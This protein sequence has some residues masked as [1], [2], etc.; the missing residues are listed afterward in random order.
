MTHVD[1]GDVLQRSF[2]MPV[3]EI[4]LHVEQLICNL[5]EII[6]DANELVIFYGNHP[7]CTANLTACTLL[8]AR[9]CLVVKWKWIGSIMD[10]FM[11][12]EHRRNINVGIL[13]TGPGYVGKST[14]VVHI[15][16]DT[17]VDKNAWENWNL[18]LVGHL[19]RGS[20]IIITSNSDEIRDFGTTQALQLNFLPLE[21][22]LYFFKILMFRSADPSDHPKLE[23]VALE[24]AREMN[25]SFIAANAISGI[26]RDNLSDHYWSMYLAIFKADI[27]RNVSLFGEHPY[28]LMQNKKHACY[29]INNKDQYLVCAEYLAYSSG[30]NVP[31]ITMYDVSGNVKCGGAFKVLA[32]KSHVL[33]Y[34][35]YIISCMIEKE[36]H[37][38]RTHSTE[39]Y[40]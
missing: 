27:Q 19:V 24:M 11:Q 5:N 8:S 36:Q 2:V 40:Y 34:K 33:P 38:K 30:E 25:G 1:W 15:C 10:F 39:A 26:L 17:R 16:N 22:Y 12:K 9:A 3:V 37:I 21:A 31:A 6:T 7:P 20:K 35:S 18:S 4:Q 14:L 29:L 23:S 32:W 13:L 28:E